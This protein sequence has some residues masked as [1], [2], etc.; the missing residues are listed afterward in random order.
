MLLTPETMKLFASTENRIAKDKNGENVSHL[1]ITEVLLVH[2]NVFN[3]DYQ[4]DS[5]VMYRFVLSKSVGNLSEISPKNNIL[6]KPCN[7]EFQE[8]EVGFTDKNRK[9]LGIE[10]N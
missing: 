9:K 6:L 7:S 1:E 2:C 3:N 5:R 8:I 10:K 4:E